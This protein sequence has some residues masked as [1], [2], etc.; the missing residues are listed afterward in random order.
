[1]RKGLWRGK[2]LAV[3]V[4]S[5]LIIGLAPAVADEHLAT[6][7]GHVL[8]LAGTPI[9][10]ALVSDG[11]GKEALTDAEGFFFFDQD[12]L[13]PFDF[14]ASK[15]GYD[16]AKYAEAT[17]AESLAG[18]IVIELPRSADTALSPKSLASAPGT[19]TITVKSTAP[20]NS[21]VTWTTAN[22]APLSLT[23]GTTADGV[24][25]WT[26]TYD[27]PA[28]AAKKNSWVTKI[29]NAAKQE[30]ATRD[31]GNWFVDSEAPVISA[32]N[33]VQGGYLHS[34]E[35]VLLRVIDGPTKTDSNGVTFADADKASGLDKETV[36]V[37]VDGVAYPA[38]YIPPT[39]ASGGFRTHGQLKLAA[40][41]TGWAPLAHSVV[42]SGTDLAGNASNTLTLN[43][44]TDSDSP[45][46]SNPSPT[47]TIADASPTLSV[48]VTDATSPLNGATGFV[49]IGD[50]LGLNARR[51]AA[52]FDAST[53][54]LSYKVPTIEGSTGAQNGERPLTD[55]EYLVQFEVRD[56]AGNFG[57]ITW[58]FTVK[59]L[60]L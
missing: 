59:T 40:P 11:A 16:P 60:P 54:K 18:L 37:K 52:S 38:T 4:G 32:D 24:T 13:G 58:T 6:F 42:V 12:R 2:L 27:V 57:S 3:F 50:T 7:E 56:S 14:S 55:G 43:F 29:A 47:G 21:T 46:F 36:N 41:A 31:G 53:G 17:Y 15:P 39:W 44:T 19:L 33:P 8:D 10:G 49:I 22:K 9:G 1:M 30:L 51:L 48:K 34:G 35:P 26:G 20:A 45:E 23:A 5:A 28:D 25:T